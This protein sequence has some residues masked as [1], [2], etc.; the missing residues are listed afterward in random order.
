MN[1]VRFF[2]KK[3]E[4]IN[5]KIRKV[6]KLIN[7]FISNRPNSSQEVKFSFELDMFDFC[8]A[9]L[10]EKLMPMRNKISNFADRE[11]EALASGL[12]FVSTS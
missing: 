5:A 11:A 1:F 7:I 2:Y 12:L 10:K 4:K 9:E 6:S 8:S 3:Q